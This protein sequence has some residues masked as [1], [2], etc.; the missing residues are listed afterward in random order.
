VAYRV[1]STPLIQYSTAAPNLSY[2]VPAGY[3]AVVRQISVLQDIGDYDFGCYKQ[4]DSTSPPVWFAYAH[5]L[6]LLEEY[7]RE[8]RWVVEAGETLLI[9]FS[10]LGSGISAYVGGYLL[11]N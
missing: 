8:G 2:L 11:Q 1:W 3:T 9:T 5:G 4:A 6:G 10:T 7:Q